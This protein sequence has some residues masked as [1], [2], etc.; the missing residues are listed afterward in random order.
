MTIFI[1]DVSNNNWGSEDLTPAGR[2]NLMQF[3]VGLKGSFAGVEHKM[4]QGAGYIDP[5]GAIAQTWCQ[6]NK[7]PFIGFHFATNEDPTR[8]VE[9]WRNA[10]GGSQCMIDFEDVDGSESPLLDENGFWSLVDVFNSAD[11]SVPLAYIPD[12]YANDINMDLSELL[13]NGIQLISSAY[14][15]GYSQG[16]AQ[17]LYRGCDGDNGEGWQGYHGSGAPILWQF[18]SS[19]LALGIKCDM[20]AYK[21]TSAQLAALYN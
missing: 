8:Q 21:G 19:A 12:W 6:S 16:N 18:T 10:G 20:N 5:Y 17:D 15:L 7:F 11:V 3:L 14:P 4:S 9:N 13:P 2:A 1:P